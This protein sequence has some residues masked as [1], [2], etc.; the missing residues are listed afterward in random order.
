MVSTNGRKFYEH[1]ANGLV[2]DVF[3]QQTL[4]DSLKGRLCCCRLA[5]SL[6]PL[7]LP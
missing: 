3:S 5:V 6:V 1:K 4:L 7:M 2:K